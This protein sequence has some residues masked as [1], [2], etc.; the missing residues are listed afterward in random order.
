MASKTLNYL[1]IFLCTIFFLEPLANSQLDYNFYDQSCPNLPMIVRWGV[2]AAIKND[3][4]MAASLLRLHFHDCFVNVTPLSIKFMISLL[5]GCMFFI[6]H[7]RSSG[8]RMNRILPLP[9][10]DGVITNQYDVERGAIIS[11]DTIQ[12]LLLLHLKISFS[13]THHP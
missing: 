13:S 5:C 3:T 8:I 11:L 6:V 4:R 10:L 9:P 7:F 12:W 1:S 2:W